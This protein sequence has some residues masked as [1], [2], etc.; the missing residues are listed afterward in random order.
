MQ[1]IYSN[2]S[3]Y[4]KIAIAVLLLLSVPVSGKAQS[5]FA[6][7]EPL[8]TD[9][10]SYVTCFTSETPAIDGDITDAVWKNSVW[11]DFFTDIEGDRKSAPVQNTRV[12]MLWDK[13]YL[14]IA[15]EI[16]ESHVWGNL[17]HHDE[18]IYYDNDF[19]IFL[20][21]DNNTHQYFEI[22]VNALNTI[23][24]LFLS[25]PY[26]NNAGVLISWDTPGLR[27][28][29]KIQG[30]LNKPTDT[31]KGWTVEMA[32]PFKALTLGNSVNIP[33]EGD[34]WRMN[35]SRVQWDTEIRNGNYSKK[36]DLKGKNLPEHNW[37]WSPQGIINMHYPERWGYLQFAMKNTK[38]V[39]SSFQLPY[40]EKQ[41]KYLWLV[42][43]RQKE[44]YSKNGLYASSLSQLG[45]D[46]EITI[47]NKVNTLKL[48][49]TRY[50]FR[51]SINHAKAAFVSINQ[52]G[53]VQ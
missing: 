36:K 29:V 51:A 5:Q 14:Y 48:E 8:F 19:E 37:V 38:E 10:K 6:G 52:E 41:K 9:P 42:Y 16:Q 18:V 34:L 50:Q 15:A 23:F 40:P 49:A 21:P 46:S 45:I 31:D 22:E 24:D 12:K 32:I 26:R 28:A 13:S 3:S 11:T 53:F 44:F 17:L 33:K 1:K 47:E 35:F 7:L 27:S 25:K 43:Y 39:A 30:S 20:D 4:S 2:P